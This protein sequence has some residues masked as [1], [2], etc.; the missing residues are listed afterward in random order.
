MTPPT[1]AAPAAGAPTFFLLALAA[2]LGAANLYYAQPLIALIA[3][4][5]GLDET[6]ASLVVTV[7]Q[8]GYILGLLLLV[9][10]GDI[11]ENRRLIG[12]I[13]LC[14]TAGLGLA[15]VST[16]PALFL[17]AAL[18]FGVGSVV[19][20]VAV[21]FA[22]HLARPEERGRKVGS[23]VSGLMTGILLARPASSMLAHW[24]GWRAVFLIAALAMLALAV[25]LRLALPQ[26]QPGGRT[27][28]RQLVGSLGPLM[29]SQPV[30][31]RRAAYQAGMF[32]AFTLFWT[33]VPLQLAAP[34]FGFGQQ[35]IAIFALAG[36]ASVVIS[37]LAGRLADRGFS[38]AA[39]GAAL[40]L[41]VAGFLLT[42]LGA[43]TSSV[44][45]LAIGA[46]VLDCAVTAN[47]VFGQRSIFMLAP[48]IRS[49]LNALY[50]ATF[51]FGGALGSALASPLYASGGWSAVTIAGSAII[52]LALAYYATEFRERA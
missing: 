34:E 47:L 33:A 29:R 42:E 39:T 50:I 43:A 23:V 38:R 44:V 31:R 52:V 49:R 11:V 28:Y 1:E 35:G 6:L 10:L 32:G 37:P 26:R 19:A 18:V 14:A 4:D 46:I 22:A 51:F 2:G 30:L 27:S 41:A 48:E 25:G 8:V 3:D 13:L 24:F 21:P 9:P 16:S 45:V 36:A 12:A 17:L 40:L 15:F 20:Q 5:I 7:G